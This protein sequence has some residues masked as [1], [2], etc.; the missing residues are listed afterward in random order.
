VDT[1][2]LPTTSFWL[3]LARGGVC[4]TA[5]E[6]FLLRRLEEHVPAEL[7]TTLRQQWRGLNLIQR[8]PTGRSCDSTVSSGAGLTAAHSRP[9]RS[10][11]AK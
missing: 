6:R 3:R 5:F 8:S 2:D 4:L 10:G 1:T 9:C 7:A 11:M